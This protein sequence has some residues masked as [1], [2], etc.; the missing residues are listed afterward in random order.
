MRETVLSIRPIPVPFPGGGV[1]LCGLHLPLQ[2]Q[3]TLPHRLT[4]GFVAVDAE[5]SSTRTTGFGVQFRPL[6]RL[7]AG[8]ELG[9]SGGFSLAGHHFARWRRLA[10]REDEDS[11][12]GAEFVV[13]AGAAV[14]P[15]AQTGAHFP[16]GEIGELVIGSGGFE[17]V[18]GG[19]WHRGGGL[20]AFL[21]P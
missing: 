20:V 19:E 6:H 10:G 16:G 5:V 7:R 11:L 2:Q 3:S 12:G 14:A 21:L 1:Q 8:R 17:L 9:W 13:F 18:I 15:P 4:T